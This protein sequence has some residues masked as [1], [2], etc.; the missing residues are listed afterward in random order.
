MILEN[1]IVKLV[2]YILLNA[3][4]VNST[5]LYK[6]KAGLSLCLFEVARFQEDEYIEGH[7]FDLLQEAL[8]TKNGDIGFENGLSGI[9]YV[10]LYLIENKFVEADFHELFG[11]NLKK[12][13]E[14]LSEETE[15]PTANNYIR[16][17]F[18][19]VFFLDAFLSSDNTDNSIQPLIDF[20]SDAAGR[21]LEEYVSRG[22][23]G[24]SNFLKTDFSVFLNTYIKIAV[25]CKHFYPSLKGLNGYAEQYLQNKWA[26]NFTTGY[27]LED[28]ATKNNS[29]H[30]KEVAQM[31]QVLALKNI[32][33]HTLSLSQR[34][35]LLYLL[36]KNKDKQAQQIMLLEEGFGDDTRENIIENNILQSIH[37]TD[38]IAGYESGIARLLLYWVYRNSPESNHFKF[39]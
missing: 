28:I 24:K 13:E 35:D 19:M 39:L 25:T 18:K 14:T 32:Y 21:L 2:D 16:H 5:G 11:N 22:N 38:F 8:L 36:R 37:P 20:F 15:K 34:I 10:L 30:L 9:G 33:P 3:Y 12:I 1:N 17:H 31:N 27:Y 26:S 29:L 23:E 4:S 7:S 6:G